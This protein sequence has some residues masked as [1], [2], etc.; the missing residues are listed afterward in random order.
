MFL[1]KI[2]YLKFLFSR[3][4]GNLFYQWIAVSSV[5]YGFSYSQEPSQE[6]EVIGNNL[7]KMKMIDYYYFYFS[8]LLNVKH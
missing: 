4:L 7:C 6:E 3:K 5:S 1:I 8:I 2:K